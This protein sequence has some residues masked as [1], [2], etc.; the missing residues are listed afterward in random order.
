MD[1]ETERPPVAVITEG[2]PSLVEANGNPAL[3]QQRTAGKR[4][5]ARM[6]APACSGVQPPFVA[7]R[8]P[9]GRIWRYTG[10]RGRVLAMLATMPAG[11][12][13][14]DTLPWHT[15][16]GGTIH[17]LREDGMAITTEREGEYRHAR[18][19]LVTPGRLIK[20][21]KNRWGAS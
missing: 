11:L 5:S 16:L 1:K 7:Y 2:Q 3:A 13:Q 12:T 20:L 10:K 17:V 18:Y 6:A 9:T 8:S 19:R 4:G 14:W 15:R 21:A